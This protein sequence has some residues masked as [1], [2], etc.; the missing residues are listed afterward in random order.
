MM[1]EPE[2]LH[3]RLAFIISDN[4]LN[5][6]EID[7]ILSYFFDVEFFSRAGVVVDA[8][9]RAVPDLIVFDHDT[10]EATLELLEHIRWRMPGGASP[11]SYF[12]PMRARIHGSWSEEKGWAHCA[13]RNPFLVFLS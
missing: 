1:F 11:L 8:C 5:Q 7:G 10:P 2:D 13:W 6:F 3:G 9:E 4:Y 12:F